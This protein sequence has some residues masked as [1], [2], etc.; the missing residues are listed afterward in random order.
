MTV[1]KGMAIA[2]GSLILL[3]ILGLGLAFTG[4]G[5]R[6]FVAPFRGAVEER[7]ITNRGQFRIQAYEQFYRWQEE[8]QGIESKLA[9]Y[10]EKLDRRE[11]TECRGL[12]ARRVNLVSR[13]NAASRAERTQ[14]QWMAEDL[15]ETLRQENPRNC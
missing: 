14:G 9:A 13:Y 6:W 7:E 2:T 12:I 8:V 11:E 10:P 1:G 4:L 15:P 3:V 5:A